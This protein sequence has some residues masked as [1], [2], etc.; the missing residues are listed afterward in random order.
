MFA[1]A[2]GLVKEKDVPRVLDFIRSRGMAC[3]VYGA[4]FL[5]DALYAVGDYDHALSLLTSREKRSWAKMLDCGTTITYEAW[6]DTFKPNQDWNHAWGAAPANI[7]PRHIAG[8]EPLE[9]GCRT[10]SV[11]PK[12]SSLKRVDATVPTIRGEVKVSIDNAPGCYKLKVTI[13][14]NTK[15][16]VSLPLMAKRFGISI[17]GALAKAKSSGR[18]VEVGTLHSGTY[19]IVMNY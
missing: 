19:E 15:A 13:P 1:L 6:D 14:A 5:L 3:S 17:N 7:L 10:I 11:A 18:R 4:Q 16:Q 8:V 9:P 2:F 12:T